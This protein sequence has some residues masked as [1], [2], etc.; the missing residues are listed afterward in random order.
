[1]TQS[2]CKYNQGDI[3]KTIV[4]R[5]HVEYEKQIAAGTNPALAL[6]HVLYHPADRQTAVFRHEP[7]CRRVAKNYSRDLVVLCPFTVASG[8]WLEPVLGRIKSPTNALALQHRR[9]G[10]QQ[11]L[12]HCLS[13]EARKI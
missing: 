7:E 4:E 3:T 11:A 8:S 13:A 2:G 6:Q 1:L 10:L 9:F 5:I 12:P